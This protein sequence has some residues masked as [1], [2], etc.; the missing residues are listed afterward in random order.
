MY[1]NTD[2]PRCICAEGQHTDEV[3]CALG[4]ALG[5]SDSSELLMLLDMFRRA[6]STTTQKMANQTPVCKMCG[7]IL[8]VGAYGVSYTSMCI[9]ATNYDPR[10]NKDQEQQENLCKCRHP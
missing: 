6:P 1:C 7:V 4:W 3:V 2:N 5:T 8:A 9:S 10:Q